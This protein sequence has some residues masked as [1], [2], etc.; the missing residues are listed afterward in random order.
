METTRQRLKYLLSDFVS[1]NLAW[2][3]FNLLRYFTLPYNYPLISL[4]AYYTYPNIILGQ[5]FFPLMMVAIYAISGYYNRVFFKSRLS[6]VLNAAGCAGVGAIVI[7]FTAIFNDKFADRLG[8]VEMVAMLWL[9]FTLLPSLT[10]I[11]ISANASKRIYHRQLAFN[12]IIIGTSRQALAL[13]RDLETK[14][15]NMGHRIVGFS[16]PG[17]SPARQLDSPLPV[18]DFSDLESAVAANDV[19]SFI[20]VPDEASASSLVG[21]IN[22]LLPLGK[23]VY[24]TPDTY[25]LI[26]SRPRTEMVA[27]QVLIDVSKANIPAS[28][29]NLKRIGDIVFSSLALV[30]I[31]PIIAVLAILIKRDSPGPVFYS[32]TRIGYKKKPFKIYKLRSMRVDAEES[33]PALS[34]ADDPRITPLGHTLRKYRL[35][36][37]PQFWNVL[38][39]DMSLVGPRP[40]REYY[41]SQIIQ[42]APYFNIVHQVRPGITSWGMVKY[43]YASNVDEMMQRIKYDLIYV[44]N[45]SFAVDLK[46]LFYTIRTVITGKGI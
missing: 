36:E 27:G 46:I 20:I 13:A 18:F 33:G 23:S 1:A 25:H 31:S 2:A 21:T 24:I 19:Q 43:G 17:A 37:L 22:R 11:T 38:K 40:E 3:I 42:R 6:D 14:H 15:R 8:N 12:S 39:G 35:D 41:L 32:Q 4:S 29:A 5:L 26:A 45:V 28:T 44:E 7:F 9:L 34:S 10:R 16:S 30:A